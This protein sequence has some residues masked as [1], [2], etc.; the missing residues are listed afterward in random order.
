MRLIDEGEVQLAARRA[1]A[2]NESRAR[3]LG[4]LRPEL[5]A[6]IVA[7]TEEMSV[8][9]KAAAWRGL[10]LS[11]EAMG[12]AAGEE[13]MTIEE[14]LEIHER[15]LDF[16]FALGEC[17]PRIAD[18]YLANTAALRQRSLL[19]RLSDDVHKNVP[20]GERGAVFLLVKTVVDAL[21]NLPDQVF[22]E[23]GAP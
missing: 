23:L 6:Y 14:V 12:G 4:T 3:R 15:N 8:S 22:A 19:R 16:V 20:R 7:A 21:D 13:R 2:D 17:D 9:A 11:V 5:V 10:E 18:R 1:K